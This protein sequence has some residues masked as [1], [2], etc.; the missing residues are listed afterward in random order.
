MSIH[1]DLDAEFD[2]AI[3]DD[4]LDDQGNRVDGAARAQAVTEFLARELV[5]DVEAID[6]TASGARGE[7][8]L[9]IHASPQDLG[10]LIGRRGR[11]IQAVRQVARAAG[12]ADGARINV[13]VA[14]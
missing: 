10:R 2:E 8:T 12:A 7:T 9:L 6:V 14:E 1:D 3:D 4:D 11:V 5:E 13:E